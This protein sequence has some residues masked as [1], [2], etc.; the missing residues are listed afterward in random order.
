MKKTLFLPLAFL[1]IFILIVSA[2]CSLPTGGG[3]SA[4]EE[5]KVIVVTATPE[6]VNKVA[7]AEPTAEVTE[8]V[9]TE[10]SSYAEAQAFYLEEF[11]GDLS[12]FTYDVFNFGNGSSDDATI[13]AEDGALKFVNN[14]QDLYTYVYYEPYIY[15]DVRIDIEA[16]NLATNDNSITLFCRYDGDLGWYEYNIDNDGEWTLYYYDY[17]VAQ[18]YVQLY[19]GGSTAIHMGRDINTYTMICQGQEMSLY[20]NGEF[21]HSFSHKDLKEGQVGFGV[22]SYDSYPVRVNVNWFEISEP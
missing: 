5:P 16:E 10:D 15:T 21:T 1:A 2:A 11:D 19:D 14:G 18:K 8:A 12:N 9:A 3:K 13:D 7:T 22:S 17:V 6:T 4:T 20:I